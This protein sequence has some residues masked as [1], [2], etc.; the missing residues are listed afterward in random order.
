MK[1]LSIPLLFIVNIILASQ[2]L[3][4]EYPVD[5]SGR[6]LLLFERIWQYCR[7][8]SIYQDNV[9]SHEN[10]LKFDDPQ[11]LMD[12]LY[13]TLYG[14]SFAKYYYYDPTRQSGSTGI[15]NAAP[16][17][18]QGAAN[19]VYFKR[20]TDST[21]YLQI[22][23]FEEYT[24]DELKAISSSLVEN[25]TK[26]IVDLTNNSGGSLDAV[27]KCADVF[28]YEDT[29]YLVRTYRRNIL[30]DGGTMGTIENDTLFA[31]NA[32]D[33]PEA[34]KPQKKAVLINRGTASA[35]EILAVA[36]R[37]GAGNDSRLM[38]DTSYGKS[39]G[40]YIFHF[41]GSEGMLEVTGFRF[42][43]LLGEDYHGKGILPDTMLAASG[44]VDSAIYQWIVTAGNML[45]SDFQ[46][47]LLNV[48]IIDTVLAERKNIQSV[49]TFKQHEF[50]M[51][52]EK[53]KI[54]PSPK[55][56]TLLPPVEFP[57]F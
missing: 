37:D 19:T 57:L 38:G 12:S 33:F 18:S 48:N 44:N 14:I 36:L 5:T 32:I 56:Y 27:M 40:Q 52:P 17:Q 20:L 45:E 30:R 10:I 46:S 7:A 39:I 15:G 42:Y 43:R 16:L 53:D 34:W 28:L 8:F 24:P 47:N 31:Q 13:D 25:T 21:A 11:T 23:A 51:L 2:L 4:C 9:P 35:S 3:S 29:P 50:G 49:Y 1:N 55:C 22:S 41:L 54:S 26:L 6:D